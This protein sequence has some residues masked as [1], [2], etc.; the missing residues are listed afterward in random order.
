MENINKAIGLEQ[1]DKENKRFNIIILIAKNTIH[2]YR[3]KGT[4]P[5]RI[6]SE[7]YL[8]EQLRLEEI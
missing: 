2:K 6:I 7:K 4:P 5:N 1:Q 8:I 3:L